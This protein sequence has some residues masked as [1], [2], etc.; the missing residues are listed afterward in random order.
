MPVHKQVHLFGSRK[1]QWIH[2]LGPRNRGIRGDRGVVEVDDLI[3]VHSHEAIIPSSE[4]QDGAVEGV[5]FQPN[6]RLL[7]INFFGSE[8][9]AHVGGL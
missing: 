8:E 3:C 5:G 7:S 4:A 6:V 9:E 1:F 2:Y